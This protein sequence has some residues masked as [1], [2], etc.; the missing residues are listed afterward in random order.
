MGGAVIGI[1]VED[2]VAFVDVAVE[3]LD[4][5][6][7]DARHRPHEHRRGLGLSQ[8]EPV[9][10]ED[11][12][13]EVLRFADDRGVGHAVEHAGHLLR[14]G[15]EGAADDPLH[16]RRREVVPVLRRRAG[17]VDDDVAALVDGRLAAGRDHHGGVVLL[18]DRGACDAVA[19]AKRGA[20]VEGGLVGLALALDLEHHRLAEQR[21]GPPVAAAALDLRP[22]EVR[23]A[24]DGDRPDVDDLDGRIEAVA[25]FGV[26]GAVE[27]LGQVLDPGIVDGARRCV[28][29]HLVALSGVAAV[30]EAA[31]QAVALGHAVRL[32]PLQRLAGQRLET[33]AEM[34]AVERAERLALGGDELVLHVRRQQAGGRED[35]GMRRHQ[36]ARDLQLHRDVAGEERA[37]AAGGD[38]G[39]IARVVA[40]PH[41]VELD[42]LDHAEL[43]D[44]QRAERGLLQ[45]HVE[46]R[47]EPLQR[48]PG[49]VGVQRHAPADQAAVGAQPAQ[50]HL[51]VGRGGLGAAAAVAGRSRIGAGR[52]RPDAVDAAVVDMGDGA[53]AGADGV[54]IDHRDHGLVVADLGIEQ[55]AHPEP[56]VRRHA[57][58]RRRAADVEGEHIVV[59]GH[60]A[61]PD[62]ADQ[63]RDGARHHQ[64]DRASRGAVRGRH[65]A[66]GLHEAHAARQPGVPEPG[67]E[68]ADI[69]RDTGADI[70]VE[71]GRREALE[72]AVERQHL[73]GDREIGV[74]AF[75]LE[76]VLDAPL[77][78]GVEVG[79][80]QADRDRID[81]GLAQR[82][83]V[84]AHLRLVQRHD[85]LA[86]GRGDPLPHREPV[87]PSHQR[88]RL[89]RQLLLQREV[90][91]LLV[92]GDVQEVAKALGRDQADLG[93]L[94][95]DGDV[96]R[97][98]GAVQHQVH[99]LEAD[100]GLAAE[101]VHAG[102]HRPRRIVRRGRHL[103][104][105]DRACRLVDQNQVRERAADID[106]DALHG[107]PP[108]SP[109]AA[110]RAAA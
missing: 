4:D 66:R 55:V 106:P 92:A 69:A 31:H 81:A 101:R 89:P 63:A 24:A 75:L 78:G 49:E 11:A 12:G 87:A 54:D 109:G 80:Q 38:Q 7:D 91:G 52:L 99:R 47:G 48:V 74:G 102:H 97:D 27:A 88:A 20:V 28:E 62:A 34:G 68:P 103:V 57:D 58:I 44:L 65:A 30:G 100:P 25:V 42:R 90:V 3:Q 82:P 61:G 70:G 33:G 29:A 10:V 64:V 53:A 22:V 94:V 93:A 8:H 6:L 84:G 19:C 51:R 85:D 15:G 67:I 96:G 86:L 14:D 23:D 9:P 21:H 50:H 77:M 41:A 107:S 35:A 104:E 71:T 98:G 45:R 18:D 16:D 36:D 32:Q 37:G 108:A 83:G 46:G 26:V 72:L 17:A 40:A 43:L 59:A 56:A 5:V 13:A 95:L 39:E 79:V 60:P 2:D 73:A 76:N 1:V 110:V 105:R